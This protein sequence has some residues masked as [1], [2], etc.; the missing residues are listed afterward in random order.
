MTDPV[1][2]TASVLRRGLRRRDGALV[3]AASG[4]G[5]LAAYLFALGDLVVRR[6]VGTGLVVARDPLAAAVRRVGPAAFEAVALVDLYH[7]RLLFSPGN[8]L[9]GGA[10]AALV[11]ANLALTYLALTQPEACGPSATAGIAAAVPALLSGTACCGPVVLLLF[12]VQASGLL[13]TAF[14][15]LVPVGVV[16]LLGT[17]VLV[18]RRVDPAVWDRP[19]T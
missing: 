14:A 6:G 2:H 9:V 8:V 15:W 10:L 13:L 5:Y 4:T 17:L 1:R 3:A 12:G 16:F 11:G 7:V 19:A 18:A